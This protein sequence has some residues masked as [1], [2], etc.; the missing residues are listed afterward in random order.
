MQD[1]CDTV[2]RPLSL[3]SVLRGARKKDPRQIEADEA[4]W[5]T[6]LETLRR[7]YSK[8]ADTVVCSMMVF[9]LAVVALIPIIGPFKGPAFA[10]AVSLS[11]AIVHRVRR[12]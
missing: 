12:T 8:R 10:A 11:W 5:K 9:I 7:I 1:E 3:W 4:D 2:A 6:L